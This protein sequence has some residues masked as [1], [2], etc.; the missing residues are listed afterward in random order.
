MLILAKLALQDT[1]LTQINRLVNSCRRSWTGAHLNLPAPATARS[2]LRIFF[3]RPMA[4][5]L[6]PS[7]FLE[8]PEQLDTIHILLTVAGTVKF[9]YNK[10]QYSC[11]PSWGLSR[12]RAA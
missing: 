8:S 3:A 10:S 12:G 1:A 6:T 5:C 2:M 4:P 11:M 7:Q 9:L